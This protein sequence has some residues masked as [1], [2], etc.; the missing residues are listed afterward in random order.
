MSRDTRM[1]AAPGPGNAEIAV[2][3]LREG[4]GEFLPASLGVGA[5]GLVTGV[6]MVQSG[7]PLWAAVT[8]SL[9]VFA[10]TAQLAA[11]PLIVAGAPLWLVTLTALVVNLRFIIY[12]AAL[13]ETLQHLPARRRYLLGYLVGD[14]PT[15][16]YLQRARHSPGWP[17]LGDYLLGLSGANAVVWHMSSLAG[18]LAA[19]ALPRAWGLEFAGSLALLA[20]LVPACRARPGIAGAIVAGAVAVVGR[21]WPLRTGVLA[22]RAAGIGAAVVVQSALAVRRV[23]GR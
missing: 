2:R 23:A 6:A 13:R 11:L 7:L 9:V 12:S 4:A 3:A 8:M 14:V 1:P 5:W 20:L 17:G 19:S 15:A 10:G 18:I 21:G 16:I 22:G